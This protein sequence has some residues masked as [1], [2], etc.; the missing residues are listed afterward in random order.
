[1][2]KWTT[3]SHKRTLATI[4]IKNTHR[5]ILLNLGTKSIT[6][7][8]LA[9]AAL[10]AIAI[11]ATTRPLSCAKLAVLYVDNPRFSTLSSA[12]IN[13][14]TTEATAQFKSLLGRCVV[15]E[16]PKS[17]PI[18]GIFGQLSIPQ[19]REMDAFVL[20][21]PSAADLETLSNDM[22]QVLFNEKT[23]LA[24]QIAYANRSGA[25]QVPADITLKDFA[26][27]LI[28]YHADVIVKFQ[29][30]NATDGRPIIDINS[31]NEIAH[32]SRI[33]QT[34][35]NYDL[36]ITNQPIISLERGDPSMHAS[37]RGGISNG[38]TTVCAKC[39]YGTAIILSAYALYGND[40]LLA[41]IRTEAPYSETEKALFSAQVLTH[42]LG[43]QLLHLGH[44]FG[45]EDCVMNPVEGQNFRKR[46]QA[47]RAGACAKERSPTLEIGAIK[48]PGLQVPFN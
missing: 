1:V 17:K 6:T 14:V 10:L 42:E 15:F 30:Q 47:L 33:P 2:R 34:P 12:Q 46:S 28:K 21:R 4:L 39:R 11:Y 36:Y 26:S 48:Y 41:S 24:E 38:L 8:S 9:C 32:W 43:H 44:P 13:A 7:I 40:S 37:L 29:T 20:R 45:L 5:D 18:A 35:L 27:Q 23:T 25:I 22:A 19:I 16:T 3:L 31:Y